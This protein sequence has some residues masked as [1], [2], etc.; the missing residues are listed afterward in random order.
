MCSTSRI[1]SLVLSRGV[2]VRD[3]DDRLLGRVQ[4]LEHVFGIG[5]V[6]EE[7]ADIELLQM[8]IAVQ[9]LV[10]GVGDGIELRLVLWSK[11]GF[12]V[13]P[14]I[15]TRHR[16]DM[17]LVAG[18]DLAE[19]DAQ[20]VVR[21]SRDMVELVHGDQPTVERFDTETVHGETEGRVRADQNR[22]FAFQEGLDRVD[23]ATLCAWRVAQI[24]GWAPRPSRPRSR[25]RSTARR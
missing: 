25:I 4:H 1:L 15:G 6:I 18:D 7:I 22:I 12:G 20:L 14:E 24:A 9:L 19:M 17:C 11:H 13:A 3:M 16:H 8:L 2:H 23:L 10:I 21:I 5:T